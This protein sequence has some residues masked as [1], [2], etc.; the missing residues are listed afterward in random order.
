M[1]DLGQRGLTS[2][3]VEG[4]AEVYAS[5][6]NEGQVDKLIVFIAPLL[7]GGQKAKGM[8]GGRGA[9]Q[10]TEAIRLKEMKVKAWAG[11]F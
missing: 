1:T 8:I 9:A 7:V 5:F 10:I 6:L 3:L 11:I 2:L 4:G